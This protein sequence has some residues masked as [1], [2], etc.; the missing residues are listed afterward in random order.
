MTIYKYIIGLITKGYS[1]KDIIK[2]C[3]IKRL[4]SV[5]THYITHCRKDYK[6][7]G[8]NND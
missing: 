3:N 8:S 4:A 5:S 6:K 2:A 1:D 7:E